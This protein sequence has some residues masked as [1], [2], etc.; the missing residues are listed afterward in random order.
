V[1]GQPGFLSQLLTCNNPIP[2]YET[3]SPIWSGRKARFAPALD[4]AATCVATVIAA[5]AV[6]P[7]AACLLL[8]LHPA[9]I[10]PAELLFFP[11]CDFHSRRLLA[12][13]R[14]LL[15]ASY[16]PPATVRQL[17]PGSYCL[18]ATGCP[19]QRVRRINWHPFGVN[20]SAALCD[21]H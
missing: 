20:A 5:A 21:Y 10:A 4:A 19:P 16:C 11:S 15:S 9:Y 13:A 3:G 18:A 6:A 12:T 2:D 17:L 7:R 14:Q 1:R 8:S